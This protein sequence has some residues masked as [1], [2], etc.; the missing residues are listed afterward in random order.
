MSVDH[1][2][3]TFD[4]A[5]KAEANRQGV[6]DG[7]RPG[8]RRHT[9]YFTFGQAHVHRIGALTFDADLAVEITALNPRL[10]MIE[11]FG[12]EWSM[13]Y[14]EPPE[15]QFAPRGVVRLND[16]NGFD[17]IRRGETDGDR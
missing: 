3:N 16:Q 11:F 6:D 9:R 17:W 8:G 15:P 14:A 2:T 13:E 10:R 7:Y 4:D 1:H 5:G 12:R